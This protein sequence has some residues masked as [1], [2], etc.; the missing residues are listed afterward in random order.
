MT[1]QA[2]YNHTGTRV[3]VALNAA[4]AFTLLEW[5]YLWKCL[6]CFGFGPNYIKW[7]QL[8]YQAPVA[9][10]S[11]NAL[12]SDPFHLHRETHQRCPPS[13]LLYALA[14]ESLAIPLRANPSVQGLGVASL[15]ENTGLLADDTL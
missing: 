4:K 5:G 12:V 15:V 1:L 3:I 7:V 13:P 14:T 9:Q 10:I 2:P 8:L 6:K 11:T